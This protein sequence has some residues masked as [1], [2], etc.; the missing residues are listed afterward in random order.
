MRKEILI[1]KTLVKYYKRLLCNL[2]TNLQYSILFQVRNSVS[3]LVRVCE[4]IIPF[5]FYDVW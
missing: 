5:E 3:C 4:M 2:W 1:S